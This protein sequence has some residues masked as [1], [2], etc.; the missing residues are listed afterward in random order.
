MDATIV[1]ARA[2]QSF[3]YSPLKIRE[4][5][6]SARPVIAPR[7]GEVSRT[8]TDGVNALLYEPGDVDGLAEH[9]LRLQS[10]PDLGARLGTAGRALVVASGTW[11]FQLQRLLDSE[12]FRRARTRLATAP[13]RSPS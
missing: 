13:D 3:H 2:G 9:L 4:Y 7:I 6:A 5:L 11:F 1:T 10:A 12:A 8:V